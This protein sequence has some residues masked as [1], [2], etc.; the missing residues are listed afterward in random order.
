MTS[1]WPTAHVNFFQGFNTDIH[2]SIAIQDLVL[3]AKQVT[4]NL[5]VKGNLGI[6]DAKAD[7]IGKNTIAQGVTATWS[8]DNYGSGASSL[9]VSGSDGAY[10]HWDY[11]T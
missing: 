1:Y 2:K 5:D 11:L 7:A 6:A 3:V 8:I 4:S 9:S 10:S